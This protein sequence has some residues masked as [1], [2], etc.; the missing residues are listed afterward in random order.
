[1]SFWFDPLLWALTLQAATALLFVALG[2]YLP[3]RAGV[4]VLGGEGIM[5]LGCFGSI[6]AQ[7]LTGGGA[8]AGILG[9]IVA[10][11]L[12]SAAFALVAITARVNVIV[13]G[14]ALNFIAAGGTSVLTS[15]LFAGS[16]GSLFAPGLEAL[17]PLPMG[18]V[19][20]IPWL[21]P[22]LGHQTLLFFLAILSVPGLALWLRRTRGG[23]TTRV[24]GASPT[25]ALTAGRSPARTRWLALVAGG[26]FIGL[27]AGQLALASV[28][29]FSPGMTSGRGFIALALVLIAARRPWL[30]LPLALVFAYFDTLGFNLQNIGLPTELSGVLPYVAILV[31]LTVPVLARRFAVAGRRGPV[32]LDPADPATNRLLS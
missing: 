17:A 25:V 9:G 5:L 1:M 27:G 28:A 16:G 7:L 23:L 14:I 29:Q 2:M 8:L 20:D 12:A 18:A 15:V 21:G 19:Q 10:A 24:T 6:A 31:M 11:V 30:L 22:V 26:V 13:T 4:L 32:E 3:M